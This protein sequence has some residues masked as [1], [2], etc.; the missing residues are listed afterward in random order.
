MGW[1]AC[2]ASVRVV[3]A[4]VLSARKSRTTTIRDFLLS[5]F[6]KR[7][8]KR[9]SRRRPRTPPDAR[10]R[11]RCPTSRRRRSPGTM[12]SWRASTCRARRALR[13]VESVRTLAADPETYETQSRFRPLRRALEP[14]MERY[15]TRQG[16]ILERARKLSCARRPSRAR[17]QAGAPGQDPPRQH[18]SPFR[19]HREP[20]GADG[21]RRRRRCGRHPRRGRWS[22]RGRRRLRR[23]GSGCGVPHAGARRR[24]Q[25]RGGEVGA[26]ARGLLDDHDRVGAQATS[27]P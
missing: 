16:E 3:V 5:R 9:Y 2:G 18:A 15:A 27:C 13:L 11:A 17:V 8:T 20:R 22:S 21:G 14:L 23:R 6:M 24:G 10:W 26:D 12:H 1:C 7:E 19:A 25:G 4:R